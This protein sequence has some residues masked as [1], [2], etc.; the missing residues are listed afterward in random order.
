MRHKEYKV[1]QRQQKHNSC[2]HGVYN[3][4][5]I[6]YLNKYIENYKGVQS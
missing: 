1:E 6:H 4:E 5:G 2:P 3:R